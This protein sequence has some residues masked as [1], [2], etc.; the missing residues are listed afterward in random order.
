MANME[1]AKLL[2]LQTEKILNAR[3]EQLRRTGGNFNIF[4]ILGMETKEVQ[5][6]SRLLYELLNPAGSHNMGDRFLREFF[7][8]VLDANYPENSPVRV[9]REY[10]FNGGR[11][12][13]VYSDYDKYAELYY[14]KKRGENCPCLTYAAARFGG[15]TLVLEFMI[16]RRLYYSFYLM[17]DDLE[18]EWGE[19]EQIPDM[20]PGT[21]WKEYITSFNRD[22][23]WW[24][25][26][27]DTAD[28]D[29]DTLPDF[30]NGNAAFRDLFDREKFDDMM[31]RVYRE[32]DCCVR[33]IEEIGLMMGQVKV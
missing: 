10:V 15:R 20:F 3:R 8:I 26:L 13:I 6:H 31:R 19:T 27:P 1:S 11:L 21:G 32:I 24:K 29:M 4:S 22:N 16:E 18:P 17:N 33:K 14:T 25:Y 9:E 7:S 30:K 12:E 23:G 5:T 28:V 2:L